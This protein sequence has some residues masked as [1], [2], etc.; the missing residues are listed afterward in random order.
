MAV[1]SVISR[2][3]PAAAAA[4]ERD[5]DFAERAATAT[6]ISGPH[7]AHQHRQ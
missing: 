6:P 1:S 7:S 5:A 2:V 4:T 3:A